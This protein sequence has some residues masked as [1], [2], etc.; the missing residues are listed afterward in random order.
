MITDFLSIHQ[1]NLIISNTCDVLC[2]LLTQERRVKNMRRKVIRP[3]HNHFPGLS[4]EDGAVDVPVGTQTVQATQ[5]RGEKTVK[6]LEYCQACGKGFLQKY[7][8]LG[9][10]GILECFKKESMAEDSKTR[11]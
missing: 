2:V 7:K 6:P 3:Y 4:V 5:L 8:N 9:S 10:L 1:T 11:N